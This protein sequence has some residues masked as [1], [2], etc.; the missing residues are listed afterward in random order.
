MDIEIY[1]VAAIIGACFLAAVIMVIR[2]IIKGDI[3]AGDKGYEEWCRKHHLKAEDRPDIRVPAESLP[4]GLRTLAPL[5]ECWGISDDV[6][7]I[8]CIKAAAPEERAELLSAVEQHRSELTAWLE[9]T[10][11]AQ[12][13]AWTAVA[14]METAASEMEAMERKDKN[15][16]A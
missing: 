2:K 8:N 14:F 6:I 1:I 7:R 9:N 15:A 4:E 16:T 5:A 13:E 3:K 12:S 11:V 10:D